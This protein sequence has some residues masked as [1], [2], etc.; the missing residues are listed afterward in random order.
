MKKIVTIILSLTLL[1]LSA[2]TGN[3]EPT[4]ETKT[5][6]TTASEIVTESTE[7]VSETE[8]EPET[9]AEPE[10]TETETTKAPETTE[11]AETTEEQTTTAE[12]KK[13]V[14]ELWPVFE[15]FLNE[16]GINALLS[17][18]FNDVSAGYASEIMCQLASDDHIDPS[19]YIDEI[20][21]EGVFFEDA[22]HM[23]VLTKKEL[24]DYVLKTTGLQLSD[25]R[26]D[27]LPYYLESEQIYYIY[28]GD[29]NYRKVFVSDIKELESGNYA[30]YYTGNDSWHF[31][32]A[33]HESDW[34]YAFD[35]ADEMAAVLSFD[36]E[37]PKLISN[38]YV[39]TPVNAQDHLENYMN[40]AGNN[41]ALRCLFDD[42]TKMDLYDIVYQMDEMSP[43]M[44]DLLM[45]ELTG[46]PLEEIQSVCDP[47]ISEAGTYS[48]Q[49]SDT[50]FQPV[51]IDSVEVS[52]NKTEESIQ[53]IYH[54]GFGDWH[55][56]RGESNNFDDSSSHG[57]A[58]QMIA[59]LS[60]TP[61]KGLIYLSNKPY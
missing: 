38:Q 25:F 1:F 36:G 49:H 60:W 8:E 39:L 35:E 22:P 15:S 56:F 3:S 13:T 52:G 45:Q 27:A 57:H 24:S 12:P 16:K 28:S 40:T 33:P 31:S 29:T 18:V 23:S 41:G 6:E 34:D 55:Y 61:E 47:Q 5:Q 20:K 51:K 43:K 21:K 59:E 44:M 17:Q 7:A 58:G 30:V 26:E 14:E 4:G 46:H 11:E 42:N 9:S 50:N 10:A 19:A 48:V 37:Q 54:S 32:R 2:C 53:V